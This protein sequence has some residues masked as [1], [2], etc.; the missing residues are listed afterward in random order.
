[1]PA[2]QIPSLQRYLRTHTAAD[3]LQR[4]NRGFA[5]QAG[6]IVFTFALVSFP[7]L[8]FAAAL[9]LLVQRWP[10]AVQLARKHIFLVTF[11]LLYFAGYLTLFAWYA[12]I[13]DYADQRFTYGLYVPFLFC[14]F[15]LLQLLQA[16]ATKKDRGANWLPGFYT[17]VAVLL[18]VDIILRVPVQ[19]TT[20]HWFGK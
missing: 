14:T 16:R 4:F 12:P 9:V 13:A 5:Q 2:D 18:A 7:L 15:Y 11:V 3:V 1:M 17:A 19:L 6:N 8:L 20:F 10:Q